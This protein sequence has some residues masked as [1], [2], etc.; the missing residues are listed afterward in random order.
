MHSDH[1]GGTNILSDYYGNEA[2]AVRYHSYGRTRVE[3]G[4]VPT[5]KRYTGQTLDASTGLYFY[6]ARYCDPCLNR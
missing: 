6:G 4:L 5:D 1:L 3:T 2:G